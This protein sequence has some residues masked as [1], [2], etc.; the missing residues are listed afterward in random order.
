MY[1][2]K[3]SFLATFSLAVVGF[4]VPVYTALHFAPGMFR[5]GA[6]PPGYVRASLS[7][8]AAV[9]VPAPVD[10][11]LLPEPQTKALSVAS[12]EALDP[13]NGNFFVVSVDVKI[14]S[15]PRMGKR[16]RL[17]SKY[18]NESQPYPGWGIAIRRLNTSTRPEVYWQNSKGKGG[19]YTFEHVRFE[20]N[21]W[22]T[23]TLVARNHDLLSLYLEPR[24][25]VPSEMPAP[26]ADMA[27]SSGSGVQFLGG[28]N[29]AEVEVSPTAAALEFPPPV[30]ENGEF[31]GQ[32]RN[33]LVAQPAHIPPRREKLRELIGGGGEALVSRIEPEELSLFVDESGADRSPAQ[34]AV[35]PA[36]PNT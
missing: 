32:I 20:K 9:T 25:P 5:Y 3:S 14:A 11:R 35:V 29:L 8:P 27:E 18:S 31:R 34:R 1:L 4:I 30:V 22:Y 24:E 15:L 7:T 19:W 12:N 21:R 13:K 10:E 17:V 28:Y 6:P 23:F 2:L 26:D 16:Q 36:V 33:V